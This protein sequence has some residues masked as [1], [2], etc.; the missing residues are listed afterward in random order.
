MGAFD[1]KPDRVALATSVANAPSIGADLQ[2]RRNLL[3]GFPLLGVGAVAG[4]WVAGRLITPLGTYKI[5]LIA[6]AALCICAA[7]T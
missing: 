7:L 5:M 4:A 6:V 2:P 3:E 1:I